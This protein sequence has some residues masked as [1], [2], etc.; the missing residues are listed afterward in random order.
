MPAIAIICVLI[1]I[2]RYSYRALRAYSRWARHWEKR[3]RKIDRRYWKA[4]RKY[5]RALYG[6]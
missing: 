4:E 5:D 3:E 2:Y 1:P 6:Y